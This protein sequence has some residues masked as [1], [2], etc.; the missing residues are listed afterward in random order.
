MT[1][2]DPSSGRPLTRAFRRLSRLALIVVA[3]GLALRAATYA[4]GYP[5][6]GDE[7]SVVMSL[8][9]RDFAGLVRPPLEY[10]QQA[11]LGYMWVELATVKCL[12]YSEWALRLPA[13]ACG[14][15]SLVAFWRFASR[16]VDRR[17]ML[18]AVA[19]LAAS[20][21]PV[22]HAAEVKPY[23]GDLLVSL[24][25]TWLAW[26]VSRR[27]DSPGRWA[28]LTLAAALAV[29]LSFPSA[30]VIGG[31]GVYLGWAIL[32][33]R[34]ENVSRASCPR[35][36][37]P[38]RPQ[39]MPPR[40]D[41]ML[42][43][44]AGGTPVTCANAFVGLTV[45]AVIT[46][47]SFGAMYLLYARPHAQASLGY[48]SEESQWAVSFP[49][50]RRPWLLPWWL[51]EA[52]TGNMMAYPVGGKHF[53]STAT[54]L[55]V[56]TGCVSLW[57]KR[58]RDLLLLLLAPVAVTFLAAAMRKY[59]YGTSARVA[60][61]MAPAFCLLAGVGLQAAI[62]RLSPRRLAPEV[63]RVAALVLAALA[64]SMLAVNVLQPYKR[65][66]FS[67][68]RQAL[69]ALARQTSPGDQWVVANSIAPTD[70]APILESSCAVPF[71]F[72][73]GRLSPA[74]VRWDLRPEQIPSV[75]GCTWLLY[76]Q[77]P[78][79]RDPNVL[80]VYMRGLQRGDPNQ[81]ARFEVYLRTLEDRL[82]TPGRQSFPLRD[83]GDGSPGPT[84]LAYE[85][86]PPKGAASRAGSP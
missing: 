83:S 13:F 19:I 1:S 37:R 71:R 5:I 18:L 2:S 11:P 55:L 35:V 63:L 15:V 77:E 68:N 12:G 66:D 33:A 52:H 24:V 60:L 56:V 10:A 51:L 41:K 80:A 27:L 49:P 85:F 17:S 36:P 25:L 39:D 28:L 69:R 38:S 59:P 81:D 40:E 74:P 82:G 79:L 9:T 7:A 16:L 44:L 30:F 14:L 53:G 86:H 4:M 73:A 32:R 54:F 6:W 50:F 26:S 78:K 31:L 47:A 84:I 65:A 62:R 67:R 61:H 64:M 72:Y 20:Y 76:L 22:R 75:A 21:Y 42:S 48:F 43:P 23:A 57:R 8:V 29:W 46:A 70:Y 34:S 3:L 58:R 45:M